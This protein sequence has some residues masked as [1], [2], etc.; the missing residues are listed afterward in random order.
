MPKKCQTVF[1]FSF[2]DIPMEIDS[3]RSAIYEVSESFNPDSTLALK[4]E[5]SNIQPEVELTESN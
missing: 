2:D 3:I 5:R 4:R 1:D